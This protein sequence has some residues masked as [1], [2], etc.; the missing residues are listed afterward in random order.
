[1]DRCFKC[2]KLTF[3]PYSL[4]PYLNNSWLSGFTTAEG[5]LFVSVI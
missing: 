2:V 5:S 4:L 1:M 3:K